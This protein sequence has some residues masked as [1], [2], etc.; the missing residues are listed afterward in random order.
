MLRFRCPKCGQDYQGNDYLVGAEFKCT[1][2]KTA[3]TVP[4]PAAAQWTVPNGLFFGIV[5]VST[6]ILLASVVT[7]VAAGP[8]SAKPA[9]RVSARSSESAAV[10]ET[11]APAPEPAMPAVAP[12][13]APAPV[14]EVAHVAP[15]PEPTPV[16]SPEPA[17]TIRPATPTVAVPI[18]PETPK[19]PAPGDNA[20]ST[21]IAVWDFRYVDAG[22]NSKG[23]E[24]KAGQ[25]MVAGDLLNG[26]SV[27]PP[28]AAGRPGNTVF[29]S[30]VYA[31][32]DPSAEGLASRT[33]AD[34]FAID[35]TA[36]HPMISFGS[37]ELAQKLTANTSFTVW[38]RVKRTA[39]GGSKVE[40]ILKRNGCWRVGLT[41]NKID[42]NFGGRPFV[43]GQTFPVGQWRDIGVVYDDVAKTVKLYVDGNPALS[44]PAGKLPDRSTSAFEI[45]SGPGGAQPFAGLFDRVMFWDRVVDD[46][47]IHALTIPAR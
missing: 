27:A 8:T 2:C 34:G 5:G 26:S 42:L 44:T 12:T 46:Q 1:H 6:V 3:F 13:P 43:S 32:Y 33:G 10:H 30:P 45:G 21:P 7:M 19:A 23:R 20:A 40:A 31:T 15:K 11:P 25:E 28:Q 41:D 47:T 17:P 39:A 18:P 38:A 4:N 14:P 36:G 9:A 37:G 35:V 16:P 24:V 29:K 22:S